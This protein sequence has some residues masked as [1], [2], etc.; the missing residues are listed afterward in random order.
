MTKLSYTKSKDSDFPTSALDFPFFPFRLHFSGFC[1]PVGINRIFYEKNGNIQ[2]HAHHP[3]SH[4]RR[5]RKHVCPKRSH[6]TLNN[7][8]PREEIW[9]TIKIS[10][11]LGYGNNGF[12]NFQDYTYNHINSPAFQT[13]ESIKKEGPYS[14]GYRP[15][16]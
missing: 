11:N 8:V 4:A 9:I 1:I 13:V 15:S 7:G 12:G 5:I 14:L 10:A 6:P 3:G 16:V 2:A